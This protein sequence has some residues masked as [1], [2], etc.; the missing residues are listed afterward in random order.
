MIAAL[1]EAHFP[2]DEWA[3]LRTAVADAAERGV[4][5]LRLAFPWAPRDLYQEIKPKLAAVQEA[6]EAAGMFNPPR[7]FLVKELEKYQARQ[8]RLAALCRSIDM[9]DEDPASPDLP[10]EIT[11]AALGERCYPTL[12]VRVEHALTRHGWKLSSRGV[13]VGPKTSKLAR[14]GRG[15]KGMKRG[16]EA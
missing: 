4:T 6:M 14:K 15:S 5:P 16:D 11:V 1:L 3:E 8:D 12:W 2:G 7:F 10:S 13:W 9:A